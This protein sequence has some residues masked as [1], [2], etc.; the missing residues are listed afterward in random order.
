MTFWSRSL[1]VRLVGYFSL[2]SLITVS[3]VGVLTYLGARVAI[4]RLVFDRLR[5]TATLK[6]DALNLLLDNQEE[7]T[8]AIARL[9]E[10]QE[11]AEILATQAPSDREF[12]IAYDLAQQSLGSF[13]VGH[14]EIEEVTIL[15]AQ[16]GEILLS[17]QQKNEGEF[18]QQSPYFRQGLEDTAIQPLSLLSAEQQ[19][20]IIIS[21]PLQN[22][23][24]ENIA[25]LAAHI[26]LTPILQI[27]SESTGLG[28]S[29]KV[30]AVDPRYNYYAITSSGQLLVRENVRSPGIDEAIQGGAG[31]GLYPNYE[32]VSAIGYH[33]WIDRLQIAVIVEIDQAEAFEPARQMAF[34]IFMVGLVAAGIL[35]VGVYPLARQIARPILAITRTALQVAAG[36]FQQQAPVLT[37][38]EVGILATAF[39]RMTQH[40]KLLYR[41]LEEKVTQLQ[42]ADTA[43]R[44]SIRELKY[45]QAR[46]E[47]L[48]LNILPE[49]IALR[50]K[51]EETTIA[52]SYE[53]VSV[54]FADLVRF[55]ELSN[56]VS[57]TEL[58]E[59]LNV[60]FS[61]FDQLCDR[62][63]L[64]KIKTIGDA[65]MVVG[66]LPTPNPNHAVAIAEMALDMQARI[67]QF[68]RETGESFSLRIGIHSGAVVAGVIGIKKFIYDLWGDTVNI[69]SRMES[70]GISG[71][72]Q[73]TEAT[74]L[75]LKDRFYF[76]KRGNIEVKGK[77]LMTTY[78]LKK[79]KFP[80]V[81]PD[82]LP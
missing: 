4:K 24:A 81:L 80:Q 50:L 62:H 36:D 6:E 11:Q 74:Y 26:R 41:G 75:L 56:R 71:E 82:S 10:L 43:L 25:V 63:G 7:A 27:V 2:L 15:D 54:L 73:V 18:R 19:P 68:D 51:T 61:E 76:E 33:G 39:N 55:T 3:S 57:P 48:L 34:G 47:K 29:G 1:V 49:P 13:L 30:Y 14:A 35:T 72:I 59:I 28:K 78:L 37:Q 45:E 64:E 58:V 8:I 52:E 79:R 38:D 23:E 70:Q 40:L 21:T 60:I 46:S 44:Q 16:T 20:T 17:T 77:G 5:V 22:A 53:K 32:G 12:Q 42:D 31:G 9:S 69:A 65:Y 66:G 67:R